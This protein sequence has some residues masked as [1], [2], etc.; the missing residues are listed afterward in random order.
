MLDHLPRPLARRFAPTRRGFLM[1]MG[2]AGA[3]LVIGVSVPLPRSASAATPPAAFNPFVRI[4]TDGTVTVLN[5]HLDMGQGN[6]TGLATLVAEELD[7]A[8]AQMRAEHAPAAPEYAN[9]FFGI[10]G[11][12][13]ST[14]I[15]NS[16]EQY[17]MAGAAARA[18]LVEA[19][20]AAWGVPAAEITVSQGVIAHAATNRSA[21]FGEFADAAAKVTPPEKPAL[22]TPDRW[23]Y[24]GKSFP[25]LDAPVKSRGAPDTFAMDL[26]LDDMLTVLVA[27]PP[28]W[29][30]TVAAV[31]DSAARAVPGVAAILPG[32]WGVA[33]FADKTWTGIKARGLLEI[34]WDDSK[35]ETRG[36]AEIEAEYRA[37][38]DQPGAIARDDGG[39]D[40]ALAAAARVVEAEY[41]FPYLAH[42]PMEPLDITIHAEADRATL[43]SGFQMQTIDQA[44]AA[45]VLGLP[46][47]KVS[48][49]TFWAGGSF[50]RRAIAN[51]HYVAEA[52][53][54]AKAWGR[55]Q[56]LKVV[57]TREDDLA[58][59]YYRPLYLHRVRAGLDAA[60]NIVAWQHRVVGQSILMGTPFEAMLKDGIDESSIEGIKDATYALGKM[61]LEL[62]SPRVG[63]PVLWW[64]SVGH[65]HTAYAM[66]TMIDLVAEA[67]GEDP[68]ALRLRLLRDDPRKAGVLKLAAEKANWGTP[69]A[70]GRFRGVAVHKS[71]NTY[72]AEVAEISLDA[73]KVRVEKV[74]AAVD[75]GIA[76]NPDIIRAQI[77]G[78]VGYG[79]G[80]VLRDQITL[81]GGVVDQTNFDSYEPIRMSDMPEVEVHIVASAEAPTGVGEP[82]TPP[83]GPAVA[84]AIFKATGQHPRRLPFS[85][86]GFV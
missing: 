18:M 71:F 35:A 69:P 73:G 13:G 58:G 37:L 3:G 63:V 27:R 82:G 10:Q 83:V 81:T 21:G 59:G 86:A 75:C 38:L 8:H 14:A 40:E 53:M 43:W 24:I 29:G 84:N 49:N 22:K 16:F 62:H 6:A 7:A 78:G 56:P 1:A 45:A 23:V 68:V 76:V 41:F 61:K 46:P 30:A 31:N 50:G 80:A 19:A 48:V 5:K 72:V 65:T 4:A 17:R 74:V 34:T 64:R 85:T 36:T 11:T 15:A 12:G 33:V 51:A 47:E 32:P 70:E 9:L 60:G 67:A 55:P 66:E 54:L 52:A 20:A 44:T 79:L 2:G 26:H 39:S 28:K 57:W 25:R 42:A 77:E